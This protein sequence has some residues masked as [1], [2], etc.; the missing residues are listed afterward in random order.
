MQVFGGNHGYAHILQIDQSS[1]SL[2]LS[3]T[4]I[5][6]NDLNYFVKLCWLLYLVKDLDQLKHVAHN[7]TDLI[8]LILHIIRSNYIHHHSLCNW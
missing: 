8:V 2:S 4:I 6:H 3:E 5:F 7:K 1:E